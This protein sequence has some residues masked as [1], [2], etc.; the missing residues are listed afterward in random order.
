MGGEEEEGEDS[1]SIFGGRGVGWIV[2]VG[3]FPVFA[4]A[5]YGSREV[6][7]LCSRSGRQ[8]VPRWSSEFGGSV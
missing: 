5:V 8:V 6:P 7:S 4:P 3:V 1:L 2:E